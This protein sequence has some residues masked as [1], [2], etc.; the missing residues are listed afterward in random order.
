MVNQKDRKC[1][2]LFL[3]AGNMLQEFDSV[4]IY[5]MNGFLKYYVY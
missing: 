2:L 5:M 3:N 1:V 4:K